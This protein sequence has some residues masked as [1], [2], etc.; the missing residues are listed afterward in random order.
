MFST[1]VADPEKKAPSRPRPKR[2]QVARAC[3]WC[4]L[5]RIKCDDSQP[6]QNCRTRG[7]QCSNG[8]RTDV[9]TL[10]AAN[11]EIQRLRNTIQ[12]LQGQLS[13]A[14][15]ES[16]DQA[17]GKYA[18]PPDSDS[19]GVSPQFDPLTSRV[20]RSINL[21]S[22]T[23]EW[24]GIEI[25]DA[26]TGGAVYYGP[27]SSSYFGARM[28]R[29][30]SEALSKHQPESLFMMD[31]QPLTYPP[32]ILTCHQDQ[33]WPGVSSL[34]SDQSTITALESL[35]RAQEQY[36]I[37]LLW[38]SSHCIYPVL[39]ESDFREYYCSLWD[40]GGDQSIR[41]PSSLVDSILAVC[42]QYG[43][44]FL[45]SDEDCLESERD[46]HVLSVSMKSHALFRRAQS[47]LLDE[48]ERPSI[49]TLQSY[50][51]C[52][53]Y[54]TNTS[55]L[56]AA[57]SLLGTA[58]RV[59]QALRLHL[60]PC[61]TT[62]REYQELNRRLWCTLVGF[63]CQL[64]MALGRPQV[65]NLED[66]EASLPGDSQEH[67]L[68]SGSMLVIPVNDEISWL[69]FHVQSLRLSL[70][71]RGVQS[72][73]YQHGARLMEQKNAQNMYDDATLTEELAACLG[74]ELSVVYD[75]ARKVP[76]SLKIPRR[77]SGEP[78]STERCPV[79]LDALTP[80]WLQRQQVLLEISYHHFQMA[81][82]RPFIR[83][84]PGCP[85]IT[86]L[87][88]CHSI[89]C[90]NHAVTL[91]NII[92]QL[93]N[94]TDLLRGWYP[95]FQYQWDA[96]LCILGF[97]LANP[98]CPPTPAARKSVQ[99]AIKSFEMIGRYSVA[100]VTASQ[101]VREIGAQG[102][103]LVEKF[104]SSLSMRSPPSKRRRDT[105]ATV[106]M[107]SA[108][109]MTPEYLQGLSASQAYDISDFMNGMGTP[110]MDPFVQFDASKPN[111]VLSSNGMVEVGTPWMNNDDIMAAFPMFPEGSM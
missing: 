11:R 59:A 82:F 56:N 34:A 60:P 87:S 71:I 20:P 28:G 5:N 106:Q 89:S 111:I 74:R 52:I 81:N 40:M 84:R 48:I 63:D 2:N 88:D 98:V 95:V 58:V 55:L 94:D 33:K 92:H 96:A 29:F 73:F 78:L 53:I 102:E 43:S 13:K 79:K 49:M 109:A 9:P 50:I 31:N 26:H 30:L 104:N 61:D 69:S 46:Q 35:S 15:Q 6:C 32:N 90:L 76:E 57:H 38:Q 7:V 17:P 68:L 8:K 93:L 86:P 16:Q 37:D 14:G 99:T 18:T 22:S 51:Y 24:E 97:V 80:I 91:T 100:A 42:M 54:L 110:V 67:A 4:R 65:I 103:M 47:L 72:A 101:I 64:S 66:I 12:A 44:T 83:L 39:S 25:H 62:L 85:S 21:S 23:R 10:P 107:V 108:P 1:F 3:D 75:W 41:R 36:F 19:V 70:T 27:L 77:G 105:S 45:T